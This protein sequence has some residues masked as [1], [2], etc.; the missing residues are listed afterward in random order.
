MTEPFSSM[1][2]KHPEFGRLEL[3]FSG[4]LFELED[5]RNWGDASFKNLLHAVALGLS[6][7]D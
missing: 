2:V 4:D 1:T 3:N 5:Q 7:K 6:P